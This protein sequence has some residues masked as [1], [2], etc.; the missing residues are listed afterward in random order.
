[1]GRFLP[2]F[3]M[4][5]TTLKR[6]SVVPGFLYHSELVEVPWPLT[7]VQKGYLATSGS[8]VDESE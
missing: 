1:M 6:T 7:I 5:F 4:L 3:D 2:T 8:F